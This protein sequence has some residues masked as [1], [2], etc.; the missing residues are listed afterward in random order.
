MRLTGR[1]HKPEF[2]TRGALAT[3]QSDLTMIEQV[4][5]FDVH[6][7]QVTESLL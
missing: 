5:K 6:A 1:T 3:I 7:N 4:K 2:K